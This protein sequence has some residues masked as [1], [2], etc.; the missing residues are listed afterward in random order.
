[1]I[2]VVGS[3]NMDLVV[4]VEHHP[5]PGETVLGSDYQTFSGGKGANQAVAAARLGGRVR[6]V[7]RLGTDAFG[8]QLYQSLVREG[9]ELGGLKRVDSSTGLAL[10]AIN[11]AGENSI[12][13][14][15]GANHRL[16]PHDLKADDLDGARVVVTQLEIPQETAQRALELGKS[17]GA[18]TLL[19][20][21]P[22]KSVEALLP[23]VDVL[24]VN[25]HEAGAL[26]WEPRNISEARQVARELADRVPVAVIT[27][28]ELGTV[29][30]RGD[31]P[32]HMP[33]FD[34][35]ATDTTGAGD[36]FVGALAVGLSEGKDLVEAL[37][38]ANAAGALATTEVGARPRILTRENVVE[39]LQ[40]GR[41]G[42]R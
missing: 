19:N 31:E 15:P 26:A 37:E 27:L 30:A 21:A 2:A 14:S 36:A 7:G 38:F 28:G 1:M 13:V 20:A 32:G 18:T 40:R 23:Y 4:R 10:I 6:F 17:A 25:E 11:T 34:V 24:V 29:W 42:E 5:R 33:A 12:I 16:F 9:L 3:I 35:E 41:R 22:A 39:L 8:D